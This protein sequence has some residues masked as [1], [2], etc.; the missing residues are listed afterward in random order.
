MPTPGCEQFSGFVF[1]GSL[2]YL[3]VSLTCQSCARGAPNVCQSVPGPG[4]PRDITDPA[5]TLGRLILWGWWG[6]GRWAGRVVVSRTPGLAHSPGSRLWHEL[7]GP[8]EKS[9]SV[10]AIPAEPPW[11][12]WTLWQ[13]V[14]LRSVLSWALLPRLPPC[15][16]PLLQRTQPLPEAP[17]TNPQPPSQARE[18]MGPDTQ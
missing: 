17:V 5:L 16:S 4:Q 10:T 2:Q 14:H 8:Y 13:L 11:P 15:T 12:G 1:S 7:R 3:K 18:H 6:G 9:P